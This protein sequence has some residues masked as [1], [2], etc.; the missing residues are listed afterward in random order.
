[1]DLQMLTR[2]NSFGLTQFMILPL[3]ILA[4]HPF[5]QSLS[6]GLKISKN[7]PYLGFAIFLYKRAYSP[8]M[9][10]INFTELMGKMD[11][12]SLIIISYQA[13]M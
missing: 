1:M 11:I 2:L 9:Q 8:S 12:Y 10:I 5:S 3:G 4:F 7:L 6:L 13:E